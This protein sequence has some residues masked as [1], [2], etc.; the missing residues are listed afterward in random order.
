MAGEIGSEWRLESADGCLRDHAGV[1]ILVN[2]QC[3]NELFPGR[4]SYTALKSC[5]HRNLEVFKQVHGFQVFCGNHL[6]QL[7][8]ENPHARQPSVD[9][10]LDS[11]RVAGLNVGNL[12]VKV[13]DRWYET[14]W[15]ELFKKR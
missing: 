3:S 10:M 2:L 9:T 1:L 13:I 5:Y 4:K 7:Q 8:A 11:A 6:R 12:N 15:F 14:G